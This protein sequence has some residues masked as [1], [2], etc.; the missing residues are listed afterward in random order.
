MSLPDTIAKKPPQPFGQ[1]GFFISPAM[2]LKTQCGAMAN[3]EHC[4]GT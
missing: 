4:I 3:E 1:G 2:P